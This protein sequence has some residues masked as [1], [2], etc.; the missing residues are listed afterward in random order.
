MDPNRIHEWLRGP[1]VAV[2]TPFT[3][4]FELDLDALQ[5]NIRFM[6]DGGVK[7]GQGSLLVGGA[8]GE[9]PVLNV[10]ERKAVMSAAGEAANGEAPVLTSIQHTD[11]RAIL[12]MA[13][14]AETVGVDGGQLGPTY[15]YDSTEDDVR[16]LFERISSRTGLTL[17]IY[18]TWW[19]GLVMSPELLRDLASL[20][21]VKAL[22]WSHPDPTAYREGLQE[23]SG[24]LAT[25][26]NSNNHVLSHMYGA[27][28]FITHLSGF[29]PEYPLDI[30]NKLEA[31]D[32]DGVRDRLA[33]FKW[34]W[35]TWRSKVAAMTGGEGPFIKAAM[36]AVGLQAGPPRPPSI[37][38]PEELLAELRA[39]LAE[40]KVPMVGAGAVSA[41]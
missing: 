8:G 15:Y 13:K 21:T 3:E 23:L 24:E 26:D 38:P 40:S 2:A 12:D 5:D 19:D 16:R 1:M 27:T 17:M 9:H 22:K 11:H 7:T 20:P 37:R 10:E 4:D 31:R 14:H 36:E 33:D 32:Y 29:W 30:W 39:L 6:V 35:A 34:P 25:I 18:H 28:G 41:D